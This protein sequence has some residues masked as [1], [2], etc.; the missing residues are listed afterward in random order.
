MSEPVSILP[1][2]R[3][4]TEAALEQGI[5]CVRPD[6]SVI[7]SLMRPER[8]PDTLLGHLAWAMSVDIWDPRWSSETRREVIRQSP[9]IHRRKGTRGA[10]RRAL[11]AAGY[12]DA[13]LIESWSDEVFDG[14]HPRDGSIDRTEADHWAEY[15]VILKRPVTVEQSEQVR[16]ILGAVAPARAHLKA[17]DFTRALHLYNATIPR[18]G[19]YTR[20]IA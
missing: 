9:E 1:P 6:L 20:G 5:A 10:V 12:G 2:N 16:A 15:R 17:L 8:C 11:S 13:T 18:D 3:T 14:T 4:P 19:T 7:A